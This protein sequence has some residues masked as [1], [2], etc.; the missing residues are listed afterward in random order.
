MLDLST[1][2]PVEDG[3]P[4]EVRHPETDAVLRDEAGQAV[5]IHLLGHDSAIYREAEQAMLDQRLRKRRSQ[6]TAA[7]IE[8]E[9][10]ELLVACTV[11]WTGIVW[12]GA[13]LP[14]SPEH[15]RKVYAALP[16]LRRQVASFVSET[17]N[18]IRRSAT[19]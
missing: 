19:S 10:L 13:P 14:C 11:S 15:A 9:T 16:W 1:L 18:F 7:Q 2:A 6:T 12:Q 8:A 4:M 17:G 3:V 5:T